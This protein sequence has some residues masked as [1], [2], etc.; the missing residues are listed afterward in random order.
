MDKSSSNILSVK[1]T[2]ALRGV[3]GYT[4]NFVTQT[5]KI[6]YVIDGSTQLS[7][8]PG[9][10]KGNPLLIGKPSIDL[11]T[12][13]AGIAISDASGNCITQT[14]QIPNAIPLIYGVDMSINCIMPAINLETICTSSITLDSLAGITHF[15]LFG[16]SKI[17][18]FEV[19]F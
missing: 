6:T 8:N 9:Y 18:D 10:Q 3:S 2:V 5:S 19:F 1:A 16:N 12:K 15:G 7:G 14:S 17:S 11:I 13:S 4:D